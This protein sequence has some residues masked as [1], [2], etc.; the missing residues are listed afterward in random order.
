M[1]NTIYILIV[2]ITIIGCTASKNRTVTT[3]NKTTEATKT[4]NDTVRIAND[5]L[6]YE[7]IIIDPGFNSWLA[8]YARPRNY[9]SQQYLEARNR[10]WVIGWNMRALQPGNYRRDLFEMRIDY[11][12]NIN[13]GYEVNYMLF[14]YLAYFQ[15]TNKIRLGT[16]S[17]RI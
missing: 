8:S 13:Y 3:N 7:I 4:A 2:V 5:E 16:F 14:N 12:P 6:E 9:Y 17:P 10:D 1:K 11:D 15:I